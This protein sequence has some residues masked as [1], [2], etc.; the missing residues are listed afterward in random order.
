MSSL[1]DRDHEGLPDR[2]QGQAAHAPAGPGPVGGGPSQPPFLGSLARG[3][4]HLPSH[5][6]QRARPASS[7]GPGILWP[8]ILAAPLD[9][10]GSEVRGDVSRDLGA[11]ERQGSRLKWLSAPCCHLVSGCCCLRGLAGR[12]LCTVRG[13]GPGWEGHLT[14]LHGATSV[15]ACVKARVSSIPQPSC[16]GQVAQWL[17]CMVIL[18]DVGMTSP[19]CPPTPCPLLLLSG[20]DPPAGPCRPGATLLSSWGAEGTGSTH[21][22]AKALAQG[23]FAA[24]SPTHHAHHGGPGQ[25][26]SSSSL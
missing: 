15:G 21:C 1:A 7:R 6:G 4:T 20:P 3:S 25:A 19:P 9:G 18:A 8:W 2:L 22:R 16:V 5:G 12:L 24:V 13:A 23:S 26:S 11:T 10:R 17:L 14:S